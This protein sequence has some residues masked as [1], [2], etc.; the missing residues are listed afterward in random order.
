[1][2]TFQFTILALFT[3]FFS[4]KASIPGEPQPTAGPVVSGYVKDAS[5]G[6]TLI[7]AAI[8]VQE[9]K[10]GTITNIY[11]F[12]SLSI[13]KGAYN[14]TISYVG[15][16]PVSLQ[17]NIESSITRH[18]ELS[19]NNMMLKEVVITDRRTNEN[20]KDAQMGS[21][22]M[23]T[24]TIKKVPALMGEVDILKTL[25]LLPGIQ[26]TAEGFSG[27]SVRGGSAD[28]NMILLDEAP[29]YNASH[30][31]G[32]FS[33]FNSDA[34]KDMT[35]YK[36]DI[37]AHYGGRLASLLDI[38]MKEGNSKR[39]EGNGGIGTISSRLTLEG[40]IV[41]D[42]SSVLIS[43][44]RT[45]ADLFLPLAKDTLLHENKLFFYDL[46]LKANYTINNKNRIFISG[47][48]GRDVF[49]FRD[50]FNMSWGNETKT[51]RWNHIFNDKL[52]VNTSFINSVY[53]YNMNIN[54]GMSSF[55][56]KANI[57]DYGV[58]GDFIWYA[59]PQNTVRFGYNGY[60]HTFDPGTVRDRYNEALLTQS[61]NKSLEHIL[62][63]SNEHKISEKLN[64][65]YGIRFSAFQNIG[66]TLVFKYDDQFKA[67]DSTLYSEGKIY[68]TYTGF[69][70][71]FSASY[72]LTPEMS[73]KGSYSRTRQ[74]VQMASNSAA[75][76]PVDMWFAA[77]PNVKPQIS[78]QGSVGLFRNINNNLIELSFEAYYKQMQNQIDFRD[79][80][81]IYFNEKLEGEMR[82][83]KAISYG[84][85]FMARKQ[86]GSFTGWISYTYS[87]ARRTISGIN[88][89]NPY[90]AGHDKPHN[91]SIVLAYDISERVN[92]GATWLLTSGA[93][94]T[95]PTGKWEHA[96][97]TIPSYSDRNSYRLPAYH[98]LDLS[99][100]I[101]MNKKPNPKI[102]N[103]LNISCYNAYSRKNPFTIFFEE[104]KNQP[105]KMKA[106]QMSMFGIVPSVTWNFKF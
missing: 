66:K 15:Y 37:P 51:L 27:F 96:N 105:G 76:M 34:I 86:Y 32:F 5:N 58:K 52:F 25:Q 100:T 50:I 49:S 65:A 29:V 7:G 1:M 70:P 14:L 84:A 43:G 4:A 89:G 72:L 36:G 85:E 20:V 39:I 74:Y 54:Q 16:E 94:I 8:Y 31:M 45:Y 104:D 53:K 67:V 99:M 38:R 24:E 19:P 21:V 3:L 41:K 75:G 90:D 22:K 59:N 68:N 56:W 78:D 87:K 12:Y 10:T 18:I 79:N 48:Y 33:V 46:N 30:L 97:M 98:R 102:K 83:G 93:P 101:Q 9:L 95:L 92:I 106:Y 62:Y 80:A 28:Q 40:P 13:P 64:L 35:I 103:E 81:N 55:D 17:I 63:V 42:K 2:K 73:L 47:Y 82:M 71:R 77:S 61:Q 57:K 26:N 91:L 23:N 6:E 88:N 60:H 44:R 69:E 11:G